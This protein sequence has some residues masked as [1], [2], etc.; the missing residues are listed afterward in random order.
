MKLIYALSLCFMMAPA[1]AQTPQGMSQQ[2]M[3]TMMQAAQQMMACMSQVDQ[4][5]VKQLE[6]RSNE[7]EAEIDSLCKAGKRDEAQEKALAF[8]KEIMAS[9][10]MQQMK[11]CGKQFEGMKG[12]E[13]I[14][15]K[16]GIDAIEKEL[17]ENHV[18][19]S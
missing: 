3:Q 18:C 16:M 11:E 13:S 8:S 4:T 10:A 15:P 1:L 17:K 2:D 5:E 19:D 12:M 14:M 9:P 6:Q 7:M